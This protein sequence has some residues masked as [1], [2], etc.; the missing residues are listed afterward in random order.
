MISFEKAGNLSSLY[1]SLKLSK[2]QV[3]NLIIGHRGQDGTLLREQLDADGNPWIGVDRGILETSHGVR[4][5]FPASVDISQPEQVREFVDC[6]R[7]EKIYYLAACHRGSGQRLEDIGSFY[8]ESL[9][10]NVHGPL[11]FLQAI[12]KCSPESR[13]IYASSSL[14]YGP[15]SDPDKRINENTSQNPQETYAL[16]KALVGRY[17]QQYRD[18]T[19]IFASV[20]ILFN[21]DSQH[22][23][24]GFFTRDVTDALAKIARGKMSSWEVGSLDFVVDWLYAGDVV[25]AMKRIISLDCPDDFIVASGQGHTTGEF[26]QIACEMLGLDQKTCIRCNTKKLFRKENRRVGD[27]GKLRKTTGWKPSMTF[28]EMVRYLT[29]AAIERLDKEQA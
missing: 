11:N 21:H 2:E 7:P 18:Q 3:Q 15:K 8:N 12:R 16:E 28:P 25:D 9:S 14:I 5:P 10:V 17:C 6:C 1:R 4:L 27:S 23:P 13:F 22:R 26:I 29:Q 20:A 24:K 19:G